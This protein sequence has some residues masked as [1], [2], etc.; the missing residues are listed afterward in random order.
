M[1]LPNMMID[2]RDQGRS[3]LGIE[4]KGRTTSVAVFDICL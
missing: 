4:L 3:V 2:T 1:G